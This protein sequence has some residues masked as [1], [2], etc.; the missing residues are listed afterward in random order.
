MTDYPAFFRM[1]NAKRLAALRANADILNGVRN[2][3]TLSK[4]TP[5]LCIGYSGAEWDLDGNPINGTTVPFNGG[6][7][8]HDKC[9]CTLVAISK[10]FREIGWDIDDPPI[11]T[12]ASDEGQIP[13]DI[14]F[15]DFL[16]R[17]SSSYVDD[18]LGIDRAALWRSGKLTCRDLVD[19]SGQLVPLEALLGREEGPAPR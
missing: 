12:R 13:A 1:A 5:L 19:D 9:N 10:S 4:S 17:K 18:I 15:D 7:P 2:L 3:T 11:S 6:P 16:K 14:T 8:H